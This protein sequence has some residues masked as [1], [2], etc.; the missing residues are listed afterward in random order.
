MPRN[1]ISLLC[2]LYPASQ[3]K[4][5]KASS[6]FP[7]QTI[8]CTHTAQKILD[9]LQKGARD[10][11]RK[12]EAKCTTWSYF[13]PFPPPK[14]ADAQLVIG[15]LEIYTEKQALQKQLDDPAFFQAYHETAKNESLYS[16]GEELVAWYLAAGFVA[17]EEHARPFGGCLIS[18]TKFVGDREAV[19]KAIEY[20][21]AARS[22][23]VSL[24]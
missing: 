9:L 11:Y 2:T 3:Q 17:R 19:L 7:R 24:G 14:T 1:D 4:Q 6:R 5:K 21:F 10:Y 18:L 22:C 15:G 12:P 8:A 16:R 20:G 23:C 13:T